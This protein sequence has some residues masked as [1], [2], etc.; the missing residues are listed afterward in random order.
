MLNII[1]KRFIYSG[2]G[3]SIALFV[4]GLYR[5]ILLGLLGSSLGEA[6]CTGILNTVNYVGRSSQPNLRAS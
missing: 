4:T 6:A 5:N 2:V 1:P 3:S